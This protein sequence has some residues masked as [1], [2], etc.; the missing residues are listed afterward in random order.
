M[1]NRCGRIVEFVGI[2]GQRQHVCEGLV[3]LGYQGDP[4]SGSYFGDGWL[5]VGVWGAL[6]H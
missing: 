1:E 2:T 5:G 3:I 4:R 6:F